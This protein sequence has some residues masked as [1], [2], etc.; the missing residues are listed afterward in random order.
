MS[1]TANTTGVAIVTGASRG[2]GRAVASALAEAGWQVVVDGRDERTLTAA[3]GGLA[4]VTMV[5]GDVRDPAHQQQLVDTATGI[6][7]LRLLVNNAGVLGPS[8]QPAI[9]DYPA[10]ALRDVLE[11]NLVAPWTLTQ[12]ALP[13]LRAATGAIVNVTSDAAVEPYEGWGG[14]AA[15]KAALEHASAILA[16]EEPQVAVW[17]L[18][19][20]DLRTQMHQEAF[21]DEDISDRPLPETV[22]PAF[23]RLTADRPASGRYRAADFQAVAP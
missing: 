1:D 10:A 8:P 17:W 12:H 21:P 19:P 23:V 4:G 15:S 11:A 13:A 18:D 9:A 22:A 16:A 2:L 5:V 3:V 7:P 6:G 14:Y 20:G